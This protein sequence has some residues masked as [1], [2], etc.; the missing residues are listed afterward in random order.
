MIMCHQNHKTKYTYTFTPKTKPTS[1]KKSNAT[2]QDAQGS[3]Y[4]R[5]KKLY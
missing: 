3:I 1:G 5:F 2:F 4:S